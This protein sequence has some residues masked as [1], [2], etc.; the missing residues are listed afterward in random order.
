MTDQ[1]LGAVVVGTS[2]G[3]ITHVRALRE[4]GFSVRALVGRDPARTAERARR[5]AIPVAT[6][7]LPEALAL[8]GV[9]AV[10]VATPPHSHR[11]LVLEAIAAGKHVLCE[12]PFARNVLEAHEMLGAA[13]AA[14]IV[15]L[16]GTEFRFATAQAL[17]ARAI[18]AGGIG[19]PRLAT[20]ALYAP[21]LAAPEA[22]VPAWWAQREEGGGWLGAFGSHGIDQVRQT[23]GEFS[24]VSAGLSCVSEGQRSADDS[25]TVHFRLASGAQGVLQSSAS[26][27]GRF[28]S[29]TQFAG[30]H[31]ALWL[32][33]DEVWLADRAGAR[34]LPVPDDL[35][36]GAPVP[37]SPEGLDS[38]YGQ[39]HVSGIDFRPYVRLYQAFRDCLLGVPLPSDPKP[40]TFVDGVAGMAVL[41]AIRESSATQRWVELS[42]SSAAR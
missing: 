19:E 13:E 34:R 4:A 24:G 10:A 7:S 5:Y 17:A 25:Y 18:A 36:L 40:A 11:G 20:L 31:G 26:V 8:A 28:L 2:F 15:H 16:L 27:W 30:T 23:L 37:P 35:A 1:T 12:K 29:V 42:E 21:V 41:D 39:M 9:D 22:E 6:T 32:Q 38:A 14:G 3:C 33:G